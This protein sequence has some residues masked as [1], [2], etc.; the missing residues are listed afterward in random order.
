ML[1]VTVS[2]ALRIKVLAVTPNCRVCPDG[3]IVKL[4]PDATTRLTSLIR[5]LSDVT[6]T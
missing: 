3:V 1:P 6:T 5:L 4:P 2:P